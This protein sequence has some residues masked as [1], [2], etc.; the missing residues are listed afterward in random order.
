MSPERRYD[1]SIQ[2]RTI[3]DYEAVMDSLWEE[4]DFQALHLDLA[5]I[6]ERCQR[7]YNSEFPPG[8]ATYIASLN[9]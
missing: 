6:R 2:T 4:W 9:L 5:I 1:M 8:R 7:V 3:Y